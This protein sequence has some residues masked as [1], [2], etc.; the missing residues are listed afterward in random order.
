ML[1]AARYGL[2]LM[3]AIIGGRPSGSRSYVELYERAL[4]QFGQPQLPVGLHSLGYVA[5][6]DEEAHRDPV[7][8]LQGA[9]RVGGAASAAGG[10]RPTSSS[11]RRSITA[12]CT[13]ARPKPSHSG[14]PSDVRTLG[15]SR[16]DLLYAL[17]R[18][19][20]EQRMATI[21]LYGREVI[22][23]VRALLRRCRDRSPTTTGDGAPQRARSDASPRRRS[24]AG[25]RRRRQA[26]H[27]PGPGGDRGRL[28]RGDVR[29]GAG[30]RIALTIDVL[31]PGARAV[32]PSEVVRHADMIVLAVPTHRFRELPHDLFAGKVLIDAMNYWEPV[33]GDD[34]ELAA[35]P[36]G[37]ST[38][39]QDWFPTAHVVKSL[40]QLGYHELDEP[41]R[42][43]GAPDRIAVGAAGDD[44]AAVRAVMRLVE[45]LGF[46]AV[47]A[48]PLANG[49]RPRAGR[50]AVRR[51]L[52]APTSCASSSRQGGH[53][54]S[55]RCPA[56]SS[57]RS[58]RSS[59]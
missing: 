31:A 25:H 36:D 11:R 37:T 55:G 1:R 24:A 18:V 51:H 6:T 21:E 3:L 34:D 15:L 57:G 42:P 58:M 35:A 10:R 13:S 56:P 20:H 5:E 26:R 30:R 28:R 45:R 7:A 29:L 52:R 54:L 8:V 17:G 40:N 22:P 27:D 14:S 9:V 47:D 12:R 59:C 49:A 41:A 19:P 33:D 16:F 53:S 23:R 50:L 32:R 48:G 39:V 4:E 46:D 2:P 43:S 38:V 44:R